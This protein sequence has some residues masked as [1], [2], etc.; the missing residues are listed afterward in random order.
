MSR[1]CVICTVL[2][3]TPFGGGGWS[4]EGKA[5]DVSRTRATTLKILGVGRRLVMSHVDLVRIT[6]RYVDVKTQLD[7]VRSEMNV[8]RRTAH[9]TQLFPRTAKGV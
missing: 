3:S 6:Q 7:H 2:T 9:L 5:L 4:G 1:L 8:Y